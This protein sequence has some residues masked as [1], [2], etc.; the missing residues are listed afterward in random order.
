MKTFF[1]AGPCF[2]AMTEVILQN[3]PNAPS[4]SWSDKI[5]RIATSSPLS[6]RTPKEITGRNPI[7][8]WP[9]PTRPELAGFQ[10]PRD[11]LWKGLI[12]GS[13]SEARENFHRCLSW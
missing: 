5:G 7:T 1:S 10:A 13:S 6:A 2:D 11:S 4:G 3:R 8:H 9:V 12:Y